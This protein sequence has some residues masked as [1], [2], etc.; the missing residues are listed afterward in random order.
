M[1][2]ILDFLFMALIVEAIVECYKRIGVF[3]FLNFKPFNCMFCMAV[4][5]SVIIFLIYNYTDAKEAYTVLLTFVVWR[6][7]T[8]IHGVFKYLENGNILNFEINNIDIK[9]DED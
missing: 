3:R 8:L 4:W 9:R 1:D 5:V 2:R 6:F 7:S